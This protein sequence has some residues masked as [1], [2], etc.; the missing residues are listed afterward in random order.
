ML[1]LV[2]LVKPDVSEE[3]S[4]SMINVVP[5]SS[6]LVT[7][8]MDA[9]SSSATSVLSRATRRNIPED[10]FIHSHRREGLKSYMDVF[11]SL[12][13]ATNTIT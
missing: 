1:R 6:I 9:L 7:L 10:G 11:V 13:T 3:L 2:V 4:T 12:K 8:I 5:N